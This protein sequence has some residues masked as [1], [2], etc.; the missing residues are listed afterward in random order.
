M[1]SR[2]LGE[3]ANSKSHSM[4]KISSLRR[5][6]TIVLPSGP[7]STFYI[8]DFFGIYSLRVEV[9]DFDGRVSSISITPLHL[10]LRRREIENLETYISVKPVTL[11]N[12]QKLFNSQ[13]SRIYSVPPPPSVDQTKNI[14]FAFKNNELLLLRDDSLNFS[15]LVSFSN[16]THVSHPITLK[17][18]IFYFNLVENLR[19]LNPDVLDSKFILVKVRDTIEIR[20]FESLADL[21]TDT[22]LSEV[23]PIPTTKSPAFVYLPSIKFSS[24]IHHSKE[25]KSKI[26]ESEEI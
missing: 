11:K 13:L 4:R 5:D 8:E 10:S 7:I 3:I 21:K 2:S 12:V 16:S 15:K 6:H 14:Y 22:S 19:D 9:R 23:R 26:S 18:S 25:D 20:R 1:N 17:I 24:S